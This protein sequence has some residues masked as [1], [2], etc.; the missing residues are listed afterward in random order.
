MTQA[1]AMPMFMYR[2]VQ[3]QTLA[4]AYAKAHALAWLLQ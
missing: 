3:A 1:L 2:C 4:L